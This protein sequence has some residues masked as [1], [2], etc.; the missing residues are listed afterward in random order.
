MSAGSG[1]STG[2]IGSTGSIHNR[3]FDCVS[4]SS[5]TT[6]IISSRDSG[7]TRIQLATPGSSA[8]TTNSTRPSASV[9]SSSRAV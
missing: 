7:A 9:N 3:G 1:T 5:Y 8:A 2:S 4:R 6:R